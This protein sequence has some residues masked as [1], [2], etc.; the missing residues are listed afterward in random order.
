[1]IHLSHFHRFKFLLKSLHVF[2]LLQKFQTVIVRMSVNQIVTEN[3]DQ[4][5]VAM[6]D[7]KIN[8]VFHQ[9]VM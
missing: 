4:M 7:Q 2:I 6:A 3:S 8:V 9:K 1:M 5:K